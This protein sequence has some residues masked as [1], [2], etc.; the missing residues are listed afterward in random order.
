MLKGAFANASPNHALLNIPFKD[1]A[2]YTHPAL[3]VEE[4]PR[5]ARLP[6]SMYTQK[7]MMRVFSCFSLVLSAFGLPSV[8]VMTTQSGSAA[9]AMAYTINR[10]AD[11][12]EMGQ[13]IGSMQTQKPWQKV[14]AEAHEG[15]T[16]VFSRLGS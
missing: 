7:G 13:G 8:G 9:T 2:T 4:P 5:Q 3:P 12:L 14:D 11:C 15:V 10:N 6:S 16:C 1:C